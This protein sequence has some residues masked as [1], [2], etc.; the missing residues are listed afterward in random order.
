MI[1]CLW[2]HTSDIHEK[3]TLAN[4]KIATSTTPIDFKLTKVQNNF[5]LEGNFSKQENINTITATLNPNHLEN[6][7]NLHQ[8]LQ[9]NDQVIDLNKKLIPLF[10]KKYTNGSIQ[11]KNNMLAIEGNVTSQKDKEEIQKLLNNNDIKIVDNTKVVETERNPIHFTLKKTNEYISIDGTF[12]N[13]E[14]LDSFLNL[15]NH[16]DIRKNILFDKKLYGDQKVME[17]TQNLIPFLTE[18]YQGGEINY[19]KN[20]LSLTGTVGNEALLNE[21]ESLL[22]QSG[23]NYTNETEVVTQPSAEALAKAQAEKEARLKAKAQAE[24]EARLKAEAKAKAQAEEAQK[25]ETQIK[26][27]IKIENI[28]FNLNKAT[29]T[30]ESLNTIKNIADVLKQ[31]PNVNV[32]IGG[33]TDNTGNPNY[34]LILSQKRVDM[35]KKK[36]IEMQINEQRLKAVGYGE[37]QPRVSNDTP[38]NRSKNRRVEFKVIGE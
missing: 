18:H 22:K 26:E 30:Q 27:V 38:E 11:Y 34:N 17:V 33:H 29:L 9:P 5:K 32:E 12:Q 25:I 8:G 16:H 35:V 31:H 1:I 21:V 3:R 6:K 7:S 15:I 20:S 4:S 37:T 13:R 36:L 10:A 24:E 28:N 2:C 14:N 23:V 19:N